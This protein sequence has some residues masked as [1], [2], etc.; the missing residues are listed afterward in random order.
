VIVLIT[1]GNPTVEVDFLQA[2]ARLI[3]SLGTRI[4]GVGVTSEVADCADIIIVIII[5]LFLYPRVVKS[6][7][8]VKSRLALPF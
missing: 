7:A 6:L 4:V 1:D 5:L 3:K 8:S 2:E